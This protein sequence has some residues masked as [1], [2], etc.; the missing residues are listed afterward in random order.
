MS[1]W[2]YNNIFCINSGNS[3]N[4]KRIKWMAGT[5]AKN[6]GQE[7]QKL[8]QANNDGWWWI[9]MQQQLLANCR[10]NEIVENGNK[11]RKSCSKRR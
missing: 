5:A 6:A 2:E 7:V 10:R 9:I 1:I 4:Q 8:D 11:R 3:L